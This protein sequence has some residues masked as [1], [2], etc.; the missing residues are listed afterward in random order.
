MLCTNLSLCLI[1]RN[2]LFHT[3]YVPHFQ[4]FNSYSRQGQQASEQMWNKLQC[5]Y[6]NIMHVLMEWAKGD[7]LW[8]ISYLSYT[9]SRGL[10]DRGP[11]DCSNNFKGLSTKVKN[12]S[13]QFQAKHSEWKMLWVGAQVALN[14][15]RKRVSLQ[16]KCKQKSSASC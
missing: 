12:W 13:T 9:S 5:G 7:N 3:D 2:K 15:R 10:Q 8:Q 14:A 11:L 1:H 6:F 4:L 16:E